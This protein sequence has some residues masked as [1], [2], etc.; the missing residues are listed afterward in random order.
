MAEVGGFQ[1]S[2]VERQSEAEYLSSIPPQ[3]VPVYN[4]LKATETLDAGL[5]KC[6]WYSGTLEMWS[7][8]GVKDY[9]ATVREWR[10]SWRKELGRYDLRNVRYRYEG[11]D[12][13]GIVNIIYKGK[14]HDGLFVIR[15]DGVWKLRG[16]D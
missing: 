4:M 12:S 9:E 6:V 5:F 1:N 14:E 7:S 13:R 10:K 8:W 15:E 3:A 2:K 16:G 11:D